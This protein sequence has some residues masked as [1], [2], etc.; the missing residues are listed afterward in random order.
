[1][2][3]HPL[4]AFGYEHRAPMRRHAHASPPGRA[5][6]PATEN[7][8]VTLDESAAAYIVTLSAPD[9]WTLEGER[10]ALSDDGRA[11]VLQGTMKKRSDLN[12]YQTR[13]RAGVYSAPSSRALVGVLPPGERVN[14]GA[15]TSGGWIALDDDESWMLDDGSLAY[16][17]RVD[18]ACRPAPFAKRV[19]LPA[20]ADL[21]RATSKPRRHE[22]GGLTISVPRIARQ[23]AKPQPRQIPINV[24]PAYSRAAPGAPV[25]AA[26]RPAARPSYAPPAPVRQNATRSAPPKHAAATAP[27]HPRSVSADE[28]KQQHKRQAAERRAGMRDALSALHGEGYEGPV[29]TECT[30]SDVSSRNVQS[31]TEHVE[32]WVALTDGRFVKADDEQLVAEAKRDAE[33]QMSTRAAGAVE[34]DGGSDSTSDDEEEELSYWGF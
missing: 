11:L 20:D 25:S 15:P 34:V 23:P 8:C 18:D 12:Q 14:G 27:A 10:A 5:P 13:R 29:L 16:V 1:M 19:A 17:G 7:P 24:K 28:F 4:D 2:L 32:D 30:A 26:A 3:L 9:D 22:G 31:P 6:S 21:R 33:R